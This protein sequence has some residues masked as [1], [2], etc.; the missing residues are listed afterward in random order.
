MSVSIGITNN[1]PS[2]LPLPFID[3][4]GSAE[5]ATIISPDTFGAIQKR[6]RRKQTY[7]TI[8]VIWKFSPS[9]FSTFLSFWESTLGG[10][11]A[12]FSTELRYPKI[13]DLDTWIVRFVGDISVENIE[14][15][16][17]QVGADLQV[18]R[19]ATVADA[20]ALVISGFFLVQDESSDG[21]P[22]QTFYV[23]DDASSA[24]IA[25]AF[26]VQD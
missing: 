21:M 22:L 6:S 5:V 25:R 12:K 4:S 15:T 3:Y 23:Q 10:G 11:T 7:A 13:T 18:I 8:S 9:Q 26:I 24:A 2:E 1:W 17:Y 20:A 14:D 19:L 16:I